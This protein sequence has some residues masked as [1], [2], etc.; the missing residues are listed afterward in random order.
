MKTLN[1]NHGENKM[2]KV[3]G[4]EFLNLSEMYQIRG[5]GDEEVKQPKPID[6]Y[7]TRED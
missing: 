3:A 7:D 4:I 2:S 6:V 1:C 5:G